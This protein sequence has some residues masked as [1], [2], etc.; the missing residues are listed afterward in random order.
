MNINSNYLLF[1]G[2]KI[3]YKLEK[4]FK[5]YYN[6]VKTIGIIG[7]IG[8]SKDLWDTTFYNVELILII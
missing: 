2:T 5:Y 8:N 1:F 6:N 7:C 4:I 3:E